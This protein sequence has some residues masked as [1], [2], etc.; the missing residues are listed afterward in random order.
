MI[1][2][3]SDERI[4]HW[5]TVLRMQYQFCGDALIPRKSPDAPDPFQMAAIREAH[6]SIIPILEHLVYYQDKTDGLMADLHELIRVC[7]TNP[8]GLDDFIK[9]NYPEEY[10]NHTSKRS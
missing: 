9:M 8:A 10:A 1:N 7:L 6:C 5:L 2:N 3:L 4:G